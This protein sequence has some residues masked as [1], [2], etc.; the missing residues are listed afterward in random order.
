MKLKRIL[1]SIL[2]VLV[3]AGATICYIRWD[4]WFYIPPEPNYELL[5]TPQRVIVTPGEKAIHQR[6]ISWVTGTDSTQT[7]L[8]LS[9]D[10]VWVTQNTH[11]KNVKTHGGNTIIYNAQLRVENTPRHDVWLDIGTQVDP[12]WWG[13]H[14]GERHK[15]AES[16]GFTAD[17][18]T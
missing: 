17:P 5:D 12:L 7:L 16:A 14:T 8:L 2:L 13:R 9:P 18:Q 15:G 4:A 11:T 3:I 1:W 10:S 6:N